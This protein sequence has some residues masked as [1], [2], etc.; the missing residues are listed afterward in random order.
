M[1]RI[2]G[3]WTA[4]AVAA[5]LFGVSFYVLISWL[6]QGQ[7][8][9][10]PLYLHYAGLMRGGAVPY[11]DFAFEYP[12]AALPP[13]LLAEYMSWS[14]ATSFA[15]LM[16]L[17]GAGCIFAAASALSAVRR[18]CRACLGLAAGDRNL[19]A[20]P[21]LALRHALRPLADA[22]RDRRAR[23]PRPGPPDR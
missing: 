5:V 2:G 22:A 9:D 21:R 12:P 10:V 15:V 11:R 8:S 18:R 17:C 6:E 7:L 16:G 13:M 23:R 19:A 20:R 3:T 1:R 4:A 14:Y